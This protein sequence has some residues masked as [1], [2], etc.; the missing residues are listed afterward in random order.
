ML[1]VLALTAMIAAYGPAPSDASS[2]SPAP[3]TTPYTTV[4]PAPLPGELTSATPM[5]LPAPAPV[6][7]PVLNAFDSVTLGDAPAAVKKNLGKPFEID[8]VNIGEMWRYNADGGNARL[9]VIFGNS[10]ALSITLSTR[11]GKKSTFADPYGVVLG[12]TVDQL[13]SL[14][15]QPVTVADNGNRAYGD[16]AGVRWVYGFDSGL[17]T[18]INVSQQVGTPSIAAPSSI[19]VSLGHD[20]STPELAIVVNAATS[21]AGTDLE[22]GY[23]NGLRCALGGTWN[24]I[25]QTTMALGAKWIDTFDVTCS[26]DKSTEK[27]YFDVT[28]YAGK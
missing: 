5:P 23:I 18:D 10:G 28:S 20:G 13:T 4:T 14:R 25:T 19:D 16:L 11:T 22:Y 12:M 6:P 7:T 15:G 1:S 8:P 27:L 9:S 21:G 3:Q 24:V 2:A 26:T 17:I